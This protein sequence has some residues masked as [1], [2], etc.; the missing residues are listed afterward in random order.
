MKQSLIT[1]GSVC[2]ACAAC[3]YLIPSRVEAQTQV[4]QGKPGDIQVTQGKPRE[5][6]LVQQGGQKAFVKEVN[7]KLREGFEP[8]GGVST[9]TSGVAPVNWAQAMI[10]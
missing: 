8:V 2:A 3:L 9:T 6:I 7:A 5:Y 1:L 4:K 10:R